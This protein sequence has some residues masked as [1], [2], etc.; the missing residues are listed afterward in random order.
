M[1]NWEDIMIALLGKAPC[2]PGPVHKDLSL[3]IS[4][5]GDPTGQPDVQ[6]TWIVPD[7]NNDKVHK[8]E[9]QVVR[10]LMQALKQECWNLCPV[11]RFWPTL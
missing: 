9:A 2:L 8:E 5:H 7:L 4:E 1:Q 6:T 11:T 10:R 3:W